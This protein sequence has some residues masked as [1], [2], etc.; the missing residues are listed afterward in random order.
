MFTPSQLAQAKAVPIVDILERFGAESGLPQGKELAYRSPVTNERSPSLFVNPARNVFSDY[1]ATQHGDVIRL[2]QHLTGWDFVTAVN[3]L[4]QQPPA[5]T[6]SFS[7]SGPRSNDEPG[8]TITDVRP[9]R[10]PALVNY[11][12]Q[13]RIPLRLASAYCREVH[14]Q[15]GGREYFAV[16]FANDLGGWEL[17]NERY[18]G[19]SAPKGVTTFEAGSG[20]VCLFEG[21]FDFLSAL[22]WYDQTR[23]RFSTIV[24]NSTANL[25]Q[26]LARL[27]EATQINCFLDTDKAGRAAI[28]RLVRK[29][30]LPVVDCSTVY[31]G[32]KDFNELLCEK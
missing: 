14:F 7:S 5:E 22:A 31:A 12:G 16:G 11:L 19:S 28:E 24:L 27:R 1:S 8:I 32:H 25:G 15:N 23:P 20:R 2:V 9:L 30:I 17:R 3:Y 13:R 18:K 10:H 29:E 6:R 26:S 4:L 21:F